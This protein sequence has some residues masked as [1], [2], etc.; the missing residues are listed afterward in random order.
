M[1]KLSIGK[2][3]E[4]AS[5]FLRAEMHLLVP[6]ALAMFTVPATLFGWYNPSGDPNQA[7]GGLGWPLTLVILIL[8][9]AGQMTIAGMA[10]GW[11]GSVGGAL[12]QSLR[13]V[14]SVIGAAFLTF[15]PLT[16]VLVLLVAVMVGRAGLTDTS[17]VTPEALAAVPGLSFML[18]I[19]TLIFLFLATRMF[20]ISAV[21]MVETANPV[22][23]LARSWRLTSGHFFR[24]V[25]TFLLFLIASFVASVAVTVV[26]GSAMTLVAGEAQPY[27]LSALIVSLADGVIGAAIST[28]SAALVGRIYAQL[29]AGQATVPEV[30]RDE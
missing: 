23:I 25:A 2:A 10:I 1:G 14:W 24:L 12:A 19:F 28:T 11:S 26:V 20:L 7:T 17:Q 13:R 3:W 29:V 15:F 21:G 18:L 5:A 8:A 30:R 6:I 4:E 22:R 27:N 9:I 16:V